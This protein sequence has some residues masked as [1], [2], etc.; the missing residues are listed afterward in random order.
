MA[1]LRVSEFYCELCQSLFIFPSNFVNWTCSFLALKLNT[2]DLKFS[3]AF[4]LY[5]NFYSKRI[6]RKKTWASMSKIIYMTLLLNF[7]EKRKLSRSAQKLGWKLFCSTLFLWIN[8]QQC[9]EASV[10]RIQRENIK[11]QILWRMLLTSRWRNYVNKKRRWFSSWILCFSVFLVLAFLRTVPRPFS[12]Y[13][14]LK[15]ARLW[16][17]SLSRNQVSNS[18]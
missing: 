3:D 7:F 14:L 6:E 18:A 17:S 8:S 2:T 10:F 1:L 11:Q 5:S 4:S 12:Y 15:F 9:H 13:W 16:L